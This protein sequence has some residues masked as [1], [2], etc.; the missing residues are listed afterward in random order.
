MIEELEDLLRDK[1]SLEFRGKQNVTQNKK[2]NKI[3]QELRN[4]AKSLMNY[5]E[6]RVTLGLRAINA[7]LIF[8]T[9]KP[10]NEHRSKRDEN[11]VMKEEL[12]YKKEQIE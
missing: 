10:S 9:D 2:K 12:H 3:I 1:K 4:R 11:E 8:G 7:D 6:K 5:S